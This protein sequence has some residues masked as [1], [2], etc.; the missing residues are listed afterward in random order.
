V[1]EQTV[2]RCVQ[3]A[4]DTTAPSSASIDLYWL[5]L[6]AGG[7]SVRLNGRLYEAVA[8]RLRRR[9]VC[10]LYHSALE[11]HVPEGQFVIEQAPIRAGD[12]AERGVVAEGAVGSR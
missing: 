5:P 1:T 9:P 12:G 2:I 3:P 4:A 8:A 7:H 10:D 11:V 6:G